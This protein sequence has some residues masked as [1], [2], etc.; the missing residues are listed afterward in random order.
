[1]SFIQTQ[2]AGNSHI[3]LMRGFVNES[4]N[5]YITQRNKNMCNEY[6]TMNRQT[7]NFG[8]TRNYINI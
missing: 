4:Y 6:I 8:D 3:I 7:Q 1:M 5:I 2:Q